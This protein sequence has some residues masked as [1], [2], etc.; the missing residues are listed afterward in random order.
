[1]SDILE[2]KTLLHIVMCSQVEIV[3]LLHFVEGPKTRLFTKIKIT[4]V[5]TKNPLTLIVTKNNCN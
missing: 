4:A 3:I 1:M 2:K 5:V